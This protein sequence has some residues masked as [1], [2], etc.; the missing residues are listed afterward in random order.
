MNL[1]RQLRDEEK[2]NMELTAELEKEK[3]NNSELQGKLDQC[4]STIKQR[5]QFIGRLRTDGTILRH[6][7]NSISSS[8][9]KLAEMLRI[10]IQPRSNPMSGTERA[11]IE[12]ELKRISSCQTSQPTDGSNCQ[13]TE[14]VVGTATKGKENAHGD[15]SAGDV[16]ASFYD[17][18]AIFDANSFSG[19]DI[20][21]DDWIPVENE[22]NSGREAHASQTDHGSSFNGFL[23]N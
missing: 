20:D 10:C 4:Q 15:G 23:G 19:G 21:I 2:K 17:W 11:L 5:D 12:I 8:R 7:Y 22:F 6:R 13:V 1:E 14:S 9:D 3:R 18:E 16:S